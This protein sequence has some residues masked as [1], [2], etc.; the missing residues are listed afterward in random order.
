MTLSVR[1]ALFGATL[2]AALVARPRLV[3]AQ[4]PVTVTGTVTSD[5]GAGTTSEVEKLG[6]VRHAVSADLIERSNE[7]NVVEA[8]AAKAPNVSV[9]ASSGEPGSGSYITIRGQRTVG[10]P[11][12]GS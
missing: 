2:L 5:T 10:L 4:E 3:G 11:N 12:S 8:L 7:W 9:T 1:A 6:N